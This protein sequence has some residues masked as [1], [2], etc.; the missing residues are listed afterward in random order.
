MPVVFLAGCNLVHAG[1]SNLDLGQGFT[2]GVKARINAPCGE[3]A[4]FADGVFNPVFGHL[5]T[6]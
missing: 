1:D 3:K 6:K 2:G 5:P 4:L